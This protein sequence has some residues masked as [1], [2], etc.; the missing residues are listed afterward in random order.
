MIGF[1]SPEIFANKTN[2]DGFAV[3]LWSAGVIL[4]IMVTGFPPY[5]MPARE[6]E[7]FQ[8]ICNGDLMKQ[9]QAWES[10]C[11][12]HSYCFFDLLCELTFI[13][14]SLVN[15][16]ESCGDLL[17][18]MLQPNPRDRPTLSQV[19]LHEWVVEGDIEPPVP[20]NF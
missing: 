18:W 11:S 5:D 8:I 3:D 19:M 14:P 9:L 1:R 12:L 10:E 13:A 15:I 4:Y 7:R 2:F 16:S 20:H 6:D 17:Q